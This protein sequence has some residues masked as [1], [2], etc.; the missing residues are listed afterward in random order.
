M[1]DSLRNLIEMFI[2]SNYYIIL[3]YFSFSERNHP[4]ELFVV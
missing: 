1:I 4:Y 2:K 3:L